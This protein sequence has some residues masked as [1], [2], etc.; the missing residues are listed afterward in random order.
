MCDE[1]LSKAPV[2]R[3][4]A[5]KLVSQRSQEEYIRQVQE[6]QKKRSKG[7]RR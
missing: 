7:N 6:V 1:V 2:A 5:L 4:K 3:E